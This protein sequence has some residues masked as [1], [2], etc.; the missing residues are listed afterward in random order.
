M[1]QSPA[2]AKT[3]STHWTEILSG[4]FPVSSRVQDLMSSF[5]SDEPVKALSA[6][7][8]TAAGTE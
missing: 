3:L 5:E 4:R 6:N 1:E 8:V 2:Q 7:R